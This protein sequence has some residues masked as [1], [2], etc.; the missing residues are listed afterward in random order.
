MQ[1]IICNY[2]GET[3]MS[4]GKCDVCIEQKQTTSITKKIEFFR[5]EILEKITNQFTTIDY[6]KPT[7]KLQK[8]A[9]ELAVRSLLDDELIELNYKNEIRKK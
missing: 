4:C 8:T 3:V 1:E 9:F 7:N 5:N 2:F 6:F